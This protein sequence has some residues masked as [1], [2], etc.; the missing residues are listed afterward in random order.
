MST[1]TLRSAIMA[2]LLVKGALA[3]SLGRVSL[4]HPEHPVDGL[5]PGNQNRL[6]NQGRTLLV[7]AIF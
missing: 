5:D 6:Q 2:L 4:R 7:S 1:Q 3:G